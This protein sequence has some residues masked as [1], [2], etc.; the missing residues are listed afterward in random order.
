MHWSSCPLPPECGLS[1]VASL[2]LPTPTPRLVPH[3]LL[4]EVGSWTDGRAVPGV[5]PLPP[6][7]VLTSQ[8]PAGRSPASGGTSASPHWR[9]WSAARSLCC[10][11]DSCPEEWRTRGLQL[12]P[13][14]LLLIGVPQSCPVPGTLGYRD[15]CPRYSGGPSSPWT[16]RDAGSMSHFCCDCGFPPMT[17]WDLVSVSRL[18]RCVPCRR[19]PQ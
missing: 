2:P 17:A 7:P 4:L 19:E 12:S 18:V 15:N 14:H 1:P 8:A 13:R 3:P 10:I 5:A 16:Y 6:D 11:R 9:V